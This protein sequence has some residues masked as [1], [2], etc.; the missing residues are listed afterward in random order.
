MC[1]LAENCVTILEPCISSVDPI[2]LFNALSHMLLYAFL[3]AISMKHA[4]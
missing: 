3:S 1:N 2:L 4:V